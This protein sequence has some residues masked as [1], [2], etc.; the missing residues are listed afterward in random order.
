VV[1]PGDHHFGRRSLS[2]GN[3]NLRAR[4]TGVSSSR[5]IGA[6]ACATA[7]APCWAARSRERFP[8]HSLRSNGAVPALFPIHS[9][10]RRDAFQAR[11]ESWR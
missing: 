10:D 11:R 2:S 8:N 9:R 4:R 1:G 7:V 3:G 6:Q 5:C